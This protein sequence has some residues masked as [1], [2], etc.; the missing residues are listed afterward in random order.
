MN[1][2]IT[3]EKGFIGKQLSNAFTKGILYQHHAIKEDFNIVPC[4]QDVR[5]INP[6]IIK[7][8]I[9]RIYHLAGSPSP[10]MF[11]ADP[12]RTITTAVQGT[13]NILELAK[14]T[15]ARVI[16]LSTVD[17]DKYYPSHNPR[18]AYVDSKKVAEDLCFQYLQDGV[19]VRVVRLFSTYG[20]SMNYDDGRVIPTYIRKAIQNEPL[21]VWGDGTLID[22]FC[23]IDDVIKALYLL[24]EENNPGFPIEIGNPFIIGSATGLISIGE[25]AKMI[26]E[27]AKSNSIINNIPATSLSGNARIPNIMWMKEHNWTPTIGLRKGLINMIQSFRGVSA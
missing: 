21:S 23:Y 7:G 12:V 1:I 10:V 11:K 27:L 18:S 8:K 17:T 26:V 22:S 25:L 16:V 6:S 24:M 20:P 15:G 19:D 13:Y 14:K 9:D 4:P 2:L 5:D 3:G